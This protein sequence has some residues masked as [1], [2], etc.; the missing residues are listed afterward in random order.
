MRR[1]MPTFRLILLA[2]LSV[3][4]I[5]GCNRPPPAADSAADGQAAKPSDETVQEL[6]ALPYAGFVEDDDG[7]A[8]VVHYDRRRSAAGY[9]LYTTGDLCSAHLID[10]E[11]RE[12]HSWRIRPRRRWE[13]GFL[14]DSGDFIVVGAD[15]DPKQRIDDDRRYLLRLDWDS[16]VVWKTI[17]PAHHTVTLSPRNELLTL[18]AHTRSIPEVST[19]YPVC[20][21]GVAVV[22][23]DGKV[24][25]DVSLYDVV[26]GSSR[27]FEFSDVKPT[28][29][30]GEKSLDLFHANDV[31][32]LH[33]PELVDKHPMF[34]REGNV[35][36]CTRHQDSLFALNLDSGELIWTWG[37]GVLSGPH[38]PQILENGNILIFD[39]GLSRKYSR[40]VEV[41][42]SSG[43]IVWSYE[44]PEREAFFSKSR[45]SCQRLANGNT[46]IGNSQNG[47]AFEVTPQ[48]DIVWDFY[49]PITGDN[50]KRSVVVRMYR[51]PVDF[52]QRL[53]AAHE[54]DEP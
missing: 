52:V 5:S 15:G 14:T 21:N 26:A 32:W 4:A 9:N 51:L 47:Q 18:S 20:D 46:L 3:G 40:V 35:L 22:S 25:R 8:G 31:E 28:V 36:V 53:L 49:T 33:R 41:D 43:E 13:N 44:A 17:Y 50:G 12:V 48:G 11:G 27:A 38:D 37:R 1:C 16:R 7:L 24:L 45:G 23:L 29:R 6:Q 54:K 2:F 42:P 30:N 19:E 39:N 34:A 10:A